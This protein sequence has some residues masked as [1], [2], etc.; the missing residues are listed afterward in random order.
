MLKKYLLKGQ[1]LLF[2]LAL[3]AV[4]LLGNSNVFASTANTG[5]RDIS[6]LELTKEMRLGWNLGNTMDA[7]G[8]AGLDSETCW[9]N[10][11]T[12]KAMIDKVKETG[13][14][15]VRIPITWS[16]HIGSAPDYTI[17]QAWLNRVEEI[18]NYVLDNDMYAIINLHHEESHWLVPTY[19]NQDRTT[20]QVKKLWEQ[21]AT[22]FKDYSDYLIFETMNEPRVIGSSSEWS[23]GTYEN[24]A[25]INALNLAAVNTI[26]ATGG[27]NNKRF[28]MIPTHA[29]CGLTDAIN[30]LVIPNNDSRIIVSIHSYSPYLFCMVETSDFTWGSNN[31]KASLSSEFDALYNKF[32]RN[33]RAVVIGEFASIDKNNLSSRITH[34]EY[35]VQEA[36]KRG[37]PVIWW[38]NGYYGP[39]NGD[40]YAILN[41][42]AL[43][44]YYPELVQALVKASGYTATSTP[45]KTSTP[46]A[47]PTITP[48]ATPTV[49]PTAPKSFIYGDIDGEGNVNSLDFA[50]LRQFLLSI[51][52]EF[53]NLNSSSAA[54]VNGDGSIDSLDFGYMRRYLLGMIQTFPAEENIIVS[55]TPPVET[56]PGILYNGRFDTSNPSGPVCAWS[57][58]NVELNFYGTEVSA[59][60]KS[61][62]ENW[63][64]AIVDGTPLTPFV[65]NKTTSTVK[66]ASGLSEGNHH[67][68][69]WK[70]TEASQ[71]EAQFLGFDF[72]SGNLLAAPTPLQRKIEFIGDS[73]TCAYGNEGT[74]K[75]ESFTPKNENSYLSYAA[76]TARSLNA[77]A[78]LIAWSGIGLTMNYGGAGGPLMLDRYPYALPDSNVKWDYKNYMPDVVVINLGTNDFSTTPAEK[79]KYV[80][81]YKTLVS[82]VRQNYPDANIFCTIGPMLWGSGLDSCR[83][84]INEVVDSF[85]S[86]GDS[87]IYFVEFPQQSESNGYGEDWHPSLKTHQLMAD[88]LTYEIKSKLGW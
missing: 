25:V 75:E 62:G 9:G 84:Y 86:N 24:R 18:V 38:D 77:S 54:D 26:R 67:L 3:I 19:A 28:L 37:I 76:I 49:A 47:T 64:Q 53:P 69:L 78:N 45:T 4:T 11:K 21:I 31:D 43:T 70:R 27:N 74:R 50:Y 80:T 29:A 8:V 73:I 42:N 48:T 81:A 58:S 6:A 16:G 13:F 1:A 46:T 88:Q 60:I 23:G 12:T 72:G 35:Y 59:T 7:F 52:T 32:I 66:L 36:K 41:R 34:A 14:N 56:E 33:G 85:K 40:S 2:S 57:G 79:T 22:R 55:P 51:I 71:G 87:K 63:F 82:Q 15:T 10:P 83:S 5:M 30:D 65:V 44:W 17:D 39:G 61:T 68:V 20:A